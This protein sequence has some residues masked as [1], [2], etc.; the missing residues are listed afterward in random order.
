MSTSAFIWKAGVVEVGWQQE[1]CQPGHTHSVGHSVPWLWAW[2]HRKGKKLSEQ[3]PVVGGATTWGGKDHAGHHADQGSLWRSSG[4]SASG[5]PAPRMWQWSGLASRSSCSFLGPDEEHQAAPHGHGQVW[6]A[7][8]PTI[9]PEVV[10]GTH[11][12][13]GE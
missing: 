8:H 5:C 3:G 4:V 11:K 10:Q 9:G 12:V 6:Q 2:L 7:G 13:T 1:T